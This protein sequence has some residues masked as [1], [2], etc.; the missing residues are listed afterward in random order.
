MRIDTAIII[1]EPGLAH[2]I[3]R[4]HPASLAPNEI[5]D[6]G[7]DVIPQ[8]RLK[9]CIVDF[10]NEVRKFRGSEH[11]LTCCLRLAGQAALKPTVFCRDHRA[12][13]KES[14][15]GAKTTVMADVHFNAF[16]LT[17]LGVALNNLRKQRLKYETSPKPTP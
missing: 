11:G 2:R 17:S 6:A 1:S 5:V 16:S 13:G 15:T 14:G 12:G 8:R 10:F 7:D 4:N 9:R 3:L